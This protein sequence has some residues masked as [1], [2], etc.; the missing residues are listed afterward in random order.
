MSD[1]NKK[2]EGKGRGRP[3]QLQLMLREGSTTKSKIDTFL[4]KTSDQIQRKRKIGELVIEDTPSKRVNTSSSNSKTKTKMSKTDDN[5]ST[6]EVRDQL[7]AYMNEGFDRIINTLTQRINDDRA[8]FQQE[9]IDLRKE[10]E[11]SNKRLT[12]LEDRPILTPDTN[13]QKR[14]AHVESLVKLDKLD[15]PL[16]SLKQHLDKQAK[17]K[18]KKSKSV[19][20]IINLCC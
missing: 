15:G 13:I 4:L 19:I 16:K 10:M 1:G 3:T 18:K 6:S 12:A 20:Q 17:V 11:T 8:I 7:K 9:I 2:Q 14:L 5:I